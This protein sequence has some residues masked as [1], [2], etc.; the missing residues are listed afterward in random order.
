MEESSVKGMEDTVIIKDP[1]ADIADVAAELLR[2][3]ALVE[4][5][6]PVVFDEEP[7]A[8]LVCSPDAIEEVSVRMT[9]HEGIRLQ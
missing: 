6:R 2:T 1:V 7:V 9:F 3:S 8:P 5:E 4:S